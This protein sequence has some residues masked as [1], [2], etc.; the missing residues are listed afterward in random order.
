MPMWSN[1]RPKLP[2]AARSLSREPQEIVEDP[3]HQ[4][5]P[6]DPFRLCRGAG[7][8]LLILEPIEAHIGAAVA[9]WAGRLQGRVGQ[10]SSGHTAA[11]NSV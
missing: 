5:W 2:C 4:G 10:K 9:A 6:R 7:G 8:W 11:P 1:T 3:T